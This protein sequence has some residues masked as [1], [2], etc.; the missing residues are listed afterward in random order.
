MSRRSKSSLLFRS[1]AGDALVAVDRGPTPHASLT[2]GAPRRRFCGTVDGRTPDATACRA[3]VLLPWWAWIAL[4]SAAFIYATGSSWFSWLAPTW[5]RAYAVLGHIRPWL[6][7]GV[8]NNLGVWWSGA[9]LFLGSMLMF[10]VAIGA[11]AEARRPF[12]ILGLLSLGL[13]LDEV[14]SIHERLS[15]HW[16]WSP[17]VAIGLVAVGLLGWALHALALRLGRRRTTLLVLA[18]YLCYGSIA[19]QE[20]AEHGKLGDWGWWRSGR[21]EEGSELLGSLLV[22][23]AAVGE[24]HRARETRLRA[25]IPRP[26]RPP[27]LASLLTTTLILHAV[28]AVFV[29]P[30]LPDWEWRGNPATWYP[31]VAHGLAACATFW[32]AQASNQKGR[33][34]LWAMAS[35]I[36]LLASIGAVFD[37][38][39]LF[40]GIDRILPRRSFYGFYASYIFLVLPLL[41][42]GLAGRLVRRPAYLLVAVTLP[43]VLQWL[44]GSWRV[45]IVTSGF[46]AWAFA[47]A[48]GVGEPPEHR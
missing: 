42:L 34:V 23:L 41:L 31:A 32:R 18:G 25:V 38:V 48:F 9:L 28:A 12:A 8:E 44:T 37:K 39:A 10:E 45:D 46:L 6:D 33:R 11:P 5:P 20:A 27:R 29:I 2:G 1:P 16:G 36:F 35:A 17:L 4:A 30:R 14:M 47:M 22:L 26:D 19:I 43:L 15:E 21:L 7:L 13:S 24:R 3:R 40:P